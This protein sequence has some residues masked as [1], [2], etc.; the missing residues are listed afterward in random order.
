MIKRYTSIAAFSLAGAAI[1]LVGTAYGQ[2]TQ[3]AIDLSLPVDPWMDVIEAELPD[4]DVI[5]KV[6]AIRAA[7]PVKEILPVE[8][9]L[10]V[11]RPLL[12]LETL[13][14]EDGATLELPSGY[15][16]VFLMSKEVR[17]NGPEL[18]ATI[19][20]ADREPTH[21]DDAPAR[22]GVPAGIPGRSGSPDTGRQGADGLPGGDGDTRRLPTLWI[23]ADDLQIRKHPDHPFAFPDI[24]IDA[25]GIVGGN[26]GTGGTGQ[27]G[28]PGQAERNHRD[29]F[30]DCRE[31]PRRGGYGGRGGAYGPGGAGADGGPGGDIVF[32]VSSDFAE[33]VKDMR[34]VARGGLPGVG[35]LNGRPGPGGRQGRHGSTSSKCSSYGGSQRGPGAVGQAAEPNSRGPS[36]DQDGANGRFRFVIYED[37][38]SVFDDFP[39]GQ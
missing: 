10:T 4:A 38:A 27:Q 36:G 26:G 11:D 6:L 9:V 28:G 19:R 18:K 5:A 39:Q 12:F 20:Y 17:I 13:K 32:V 34:L 31:G 15:E 30:V 22:E 35:G 21:G 3:E 23:V 25:D 1:A 24:R 8:G 7:G 37:V 29:G 33:H 2:D 14:F 16:R